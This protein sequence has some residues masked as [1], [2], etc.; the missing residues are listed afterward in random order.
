MAKTGLHD[1]WSALCYL[2]FSYINFLQYRDTFG[3]E[4]RTCLPFSYPS[5]FHIKLLSFL[6]VVISVPLTLHDSLSI[7]GVGL[8]HFDWLN[9]P[10]DQVCLS[11]MLSCV[12]EYATVFEIR[13]HMSHHPLASGVLATQAPVAGV[14]LLAPLSGDMVA[15]HVSGAHTPAPWFKSVCTVGPGWTPTFPSKQDCSL[16]ITTRIEHSITNRACE[17]LN[18]F[19]R[20]VRGNLHACECVRSPVW[21]PY[22]GDGCLQ[23]P[24][25]TSGWVRKENAFPSISILSYPRACW[26]NETI[27]LLSGVSGT[28]A[29][30]FRQVG[31][32][33]VL[34]SQTQPLC[35]LV[36]YLFC[37]LVI[38]TFSVW[39]WALFLSE[40]VRWEY[41]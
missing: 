10:H 8:H 3:I 33:K 39:Q 12:W 16:E 23:S 38:H 34:H 26:Y 13:L 32:W 40:C 37:S 31:F 19:I 2:T 22:F 7:R 28:L 4:K 29:E 20:L 5:L 30:T 35:I 41:F 24:E 25:L 21:L 18:V 6:Q 11:V 36:L 14:A 17:M 27:I 1:G 15:S 9:T